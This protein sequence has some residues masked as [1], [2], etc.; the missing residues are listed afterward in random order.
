MSSSID[1]LRIITDS[2]DW[3]REMNTTFSPKFRDTNILCK[4]WNISLT[5]K[6]VFWIPAHAHGSEGK[7]SAHS[8][9][10]EC[11]H[12][13]P[14]RM[15]WQQKSHQVRVLIRQQ[16]AE[17]SSLAFLGHWW[18]FLKRKKS[19]PVKNV[20]IRHTLL[21]SS[22]NGQVPRMILELGF[23]TGTITAHQA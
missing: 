10:R 22:P 13:P 11:L 20:S 14:M 19:S 23:H 4:I 15:H 7:K 17:A 9:A 6:C 5:K 1:K 18:R 3:L 12:N 16:L 2:H 21:T 8:A